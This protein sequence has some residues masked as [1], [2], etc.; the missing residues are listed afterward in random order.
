MAKPVVL[1][2]SGGKPVVN[3]FGATPATPVASLGYPITIVESLG[4]P[5]TL[6]Y[7]AYYGPNGEVPTAIFD[8]H[9]QVYACDSGSGLRAVTTSVITGF[10]ARVQGADGIYRLR[11][12]AAS[13]DIPRLLTSNFTFSQSVGTQKVKF[14]PGTLDASDYIMYIGDGST[15]ERINIWNNAG[16]YALLITDG[17]V[18]QTNV[19]MGAV[20]NDTAEIIA[21]GWEVNNARAAR[22][23]TLGTLD[24]AVTIPTCDQVHFGHQHN[25]AAQP[26]GGIELWV[27][28]PIRM[29]DADI[30]TI[31]TP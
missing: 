31:S 1:I 25:T 29:A 6:S 24:T 21:A 12:V 5:M 19:T 18:G 15:A 17:G 2:P 27:Y 23:G 3:V 20:A 9:N 10:S 14:R 22:N 26:D 28:W 7:E 11:T 13:T 4:V 16:N 30:D 8:F